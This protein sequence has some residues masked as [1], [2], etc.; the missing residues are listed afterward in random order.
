VLRKR[1]ILASVVLAAASS[2]TSAETI[3]VCL[4]GSC[5][6]ANIQE[7][8]NA[9]SDGDLITVAAGTYLEH[10]VDFHGKE[11]TL[12]GELE[13]GGELTVTIDA[14]GNGG[15][16][17]CSNGETNNTIIE[18]I[19]VTSGSAHIGAGLM[20]FHSRPTLIN[21]TFDANMAT[22][23]GGGVYNLNGAPVLFDCRFIGNI[24]ERGGAMATFESGQPDHPRYERCSF[25]GNTALYGGAI[26]N[27]RSNPTFNDC[28]FR[29]NSAA[30]GGGMDNFQSD[31]VLSG[32][33]FQGNHAQS[34]GG[35]MDNSESN[36]VLESCKIWNNSAGIGGG[37]YN[38]SSTSDT[39]LSNTI[40]CSNAP[41]QI[42]GIWHDD[43][44]NSIT[45]ECDKD[46]PADFNGDGEVNGGD[47][48]VFLVEW[49]ECAGCAADL[50][51]DGFV[52]GGDLGAFLAAWGPCQP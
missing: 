24:A 43:G 45:E 19:I 9:V 32:C 28:A 52:D 33:T 44:G 36:P 21:C 10:E 25:E 16:L 12:R 4:D 2:V 14:Q 7:A 13:S 46:C 3:T 1:A 35:G 29:E 11:I 48:G 42:F 15:V 47:L 8:I 20:V 38:T 17:N 51:G 22:G 23:L 34:F 6:Y 30:S 27:F 39:R 26:Y 37:I 31:P 18:N 50:N 40:V 49:G 5:D 41:D